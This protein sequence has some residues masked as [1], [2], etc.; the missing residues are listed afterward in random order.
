MNE[1]NTPLSKVLMITG[2]LWATAP[3]TEQPELTLTAWTVRMLPSG[4]RHFVGWCSENCEGRVSSAVVEFDATTKC[5][6]TSTG[7]VYQLSGRPGR[8]RDAEY[9]WQRWLR[10][11]DETDWTDVTEEVSGELRL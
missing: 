10:I 1:N 3:V 4:E 5:G 8:D 6:R 2:G 11:N 7:R 9:V